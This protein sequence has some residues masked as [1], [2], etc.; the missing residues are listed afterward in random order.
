MVAPQPEGKENKSWLVRTRFYLTK[1][2]AFCVDI[3]CFCAL[4][5]REVVDEDLRSGKVW[6]ESVSNMRDKAREN[7]QQHHQMTNDENCWRHRME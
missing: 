4:A 6:C 2:M 5:D 3:Y 1:E 7:D